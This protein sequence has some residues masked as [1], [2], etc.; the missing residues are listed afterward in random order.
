VLLLDEPYASFDFDTYQK[1]WTLVEQRRAAGRTVLI[2]S[3]FV[4]DA[5]RFDRLVEVRDGRAVP[6]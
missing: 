3:H 5:E 2:I 4:V 1:F 6:R